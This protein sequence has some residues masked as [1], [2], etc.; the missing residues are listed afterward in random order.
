MTKNTQLRA[1]CPACFAIQ[2]T[3]G[4]VMVQHGYRRPQGW[5]ANVNTCFGTNVAHFGTEA[6]RDCTARIAAG[7]R[8]GAAEA[9]ERAERVASGEADVFGRVRRNGITSM[10]KIE[11]PMPWQRAEYARSLDR[12]AQDSLAYAAELETRVANWTPAE[13]VVVGVEAKVTLTHFRNAAFWRG[14]GKACA[15][16]MM[17]AMKGWATVE[18]KSVNCPKCLALAAKR[19]LV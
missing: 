19:G 6:G 13:P 18:L 16:S 15:G 11:N 9:S 10:A 7:L 8:R 17:G 12:E 1:V 5:N 3:R 2:A 14:Q 4:G